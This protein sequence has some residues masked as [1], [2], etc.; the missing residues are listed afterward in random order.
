MQPAEDPRGRLRHARCLG[1]RT[2]KLRVHI[3]KSATDRIQAYCP[4]LPG[5]SASAETE[6]EALALLRRRLTETFGERTRRP[7]PGTRVVVLEI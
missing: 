3:R 1:N 7:P 6:E 5:C 2:M 4:D